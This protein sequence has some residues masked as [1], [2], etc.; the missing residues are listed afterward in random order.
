M[1]AFVT[2]DVMTWRVLVE[3]GGGLLW[4]DRFGGN[5]ANIKRFLYMHKRQIEKNAKTE[6]KKVFL[7]SLKAK[8]AYGLS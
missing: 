4:Y 3:S 7:I 6:K 1:S 5:L 8:S 2:K